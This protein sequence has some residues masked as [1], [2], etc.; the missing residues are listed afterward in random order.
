MLS[1]KL[2]SILCNCIFFLMFILLMLLIFYSKEMSETVYLF[3]IYFLL[4]VKGRQPNF[5]FKD[6]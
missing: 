1:N 4:F 2:F 6:Q 5:L 3:L